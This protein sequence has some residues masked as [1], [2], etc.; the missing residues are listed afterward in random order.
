MPTLLY[1]SETVFIT[2]LLYMVWTSGLIL[3]EVW[4]PFTRDLVSLPAIQGIGYLVAMTC[5][6]CLLY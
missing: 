2:R 6:S 3:S 4:L 1:N 5:D